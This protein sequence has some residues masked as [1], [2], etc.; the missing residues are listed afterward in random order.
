MFNIN[1]NNE[2]KSY[3]LLIEVRNCKKV[4]KSR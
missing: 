1:I 2:F 4:R 3:L